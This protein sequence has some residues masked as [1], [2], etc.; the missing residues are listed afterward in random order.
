MEIPKKSPSKRR[1]GAAMLIVLLVLMMTTATATFA[2]HSTSVEIRAAG[3]SRQAMQTESLAEGGAYAAV[4]YVDAMKANGS[5]VQY[6]RT[7]VQAN[8]PSSPTEA[9]MGRETNLLRI[10]NGD[11]GDT[12]G[13]T[14]PPVENDTFG[15]HSVYQPSFI[16]DGTDL[17]ETT[18]DRAGEDLSGRGTHYYRVTLTSR[19]AMNIP[20]ETPQNHETAMRARALAEVGP[21]WVGGQ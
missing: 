16:V 18:R 21:F 20:G 13:A 6:L 2:I 15:P 17:Y 8:T 5:L 7:S 4:G 19:G 10:Q 12:T 1:E 3:Y 9:S 14:A 11:F